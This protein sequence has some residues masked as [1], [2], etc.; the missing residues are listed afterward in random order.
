[1]NHKR[2]T[3]FEAFI[4]NLQEKYKNYV[5]AFVVIAALL[6]CFLVYFTGG[7]KH[8]YSHTMYVPILIAGIGLGWKWGIGIGIFGGLLLGPFM[9][10]DV[11]LAENQVPIEWIYRMVIFGLIGF[12]SGVSANSLRN[13]INMVISLYSHDQLTK[14]P[15]INS[16]NRV[17]DYHLVTKDYT[18]ITVLINNYDSIVSILGQ[19]IYALLFKKVYESLKTKLSFDTIIIQSDRNKL[20]IATKYNNLEQDVIDLVSKLE[21][22][23][24]VE[25]IPFYVEYSVGGDI[26][27]SDKKIADNNTYQ[28]ADALA[29]NALKNN[30]KYLID[31]RTHRINRYDIKLIGE[32]ALALEKN[33]TFLVYQPQINIK[34]KELTG[35]EAL[36]RWNH[37]TKGIMYPD[38][39]IPLIEETQ[40]IHDLTMWVLDNVLRKIKEL[41][42]ININLPISINISPKNF[43]AP[44]FYLK[45]MDKINE[46]GIEHNLI[47]LEITESAV[48]SNPQES[49]NILKK[50]RDQGIRIALDDFGRGYSSLAHLSEIELDVLKVDKFFIQKMDTSDSHRFVVK[51]I[52]ELAH[53]IGCSVIAEG[54]ENVNIISILETHNCDLGQG[55]YIA[56]PMDENDLKGWIKQYV[57]NINNGIQTF[58]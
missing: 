10:I 25:G 52:I 54:I 45:I 38:S 13:Y 15:N 37:P 55:F 28:R 1:M 7:I 6:V 4:F 9:P 23:L 40:I 39:F 17:E 49:F 53:N 33:E 47:E 3:K 42:Q 26:L 20:W 36:I 50:F 43:L 24:E 19:D 27:R 16:L 34:T 22:F 5:I 30:V 2:N 41:K 29:R 48:M 46:S 58:W 11:N 21:H 56:M 32:F 31:D 8:S 44:D 51:A 14:V 12:A 18:I 35:F 57:E